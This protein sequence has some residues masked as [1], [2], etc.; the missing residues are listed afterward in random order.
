MWDMTQVN[1]MEAG[2]EWGV[3]SLPHP[4]ERPRTIM[5]AD[6]RRGSLCHR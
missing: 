1:H 5:Q 3:P 4:V 6:I 2:A